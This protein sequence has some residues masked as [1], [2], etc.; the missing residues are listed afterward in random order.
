MLVWRAA[1][2]LMKCG[3]FEYFILISGSMTKLQLLKPG[4]GQR[5]TLI[6][7]RSKMPQATSASGIQPMKALGLVKPGQS[8]K[9]Q[10]PL[11]PLAPPTQVPGS[12]TRNG[13]CALFVCY[14]LAMLLDYLLSHLSLD[15]R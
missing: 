13:E 5:K 1:F 3:S 10:Q 8:T 9:T 6:G 4:V 11:K 14:F 7:A 15:T 12:P 2:I